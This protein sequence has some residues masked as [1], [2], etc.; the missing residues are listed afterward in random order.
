MPHFASPAR[1]ASLRKLAPVQPIAVNGRNV[2]STYLN[3]GD[4]ITIGAVEVVVSLA[5]A[6]EADAVADEHFQEI[7]A[8]GAE[9]CK[10]KGSN[11][12]K[13]RTLWFRRRDEIEKLCR[14]QTEVAEAA[15]QRLQEQE[16]ELKRREEAWR[17][18]EE[19]LDRQRQ[20]WHARVEEAEK[21][22][23]EARGMRRQMSQI[24]EQLYEGG[25]RNRRDR[26]NEKHKTLRR[27]AKQLQER[28]RLIDEE[29][30]QFE[31]VRQELTLGREENEARAAQLE[32]ERTL[33]EDQHRQIVEQQQQ[34]AVI[35]TSARPERA[36][37]NVRRAKAKQWTTA[38]PWKRAS[39]STRPTLFASTAFRPNTI[40]GKSNW[41]RRRWR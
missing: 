2:G 32:R 37:R 8:R 10:Q 40:S 38:L 14:R 21:Q 12:R 27:A 36:S 1:G 30:V 31:A 7:A 20:E 29:T 26:L 9:L 41:R 4:R 3:S 33:L 19:D 18:G 24:R 25:Y 6:V 35:A 11:S 17:L 16:D 15:S 34:F 23:L 13:E 22:H 28:K 39:G 5:A